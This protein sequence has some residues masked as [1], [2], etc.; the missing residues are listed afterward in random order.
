MKSF[1][2][3]HF[4]HL[5]YMYKDNIHFSCVLKDEICFSCI[6]ITSRTLFTGYVFVLK[7]VKL[8]Y[9]NGMNDTNHISCM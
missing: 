1:F 8:F 6:K 7:D 3:P 9:M 4:L 2:T 5:I